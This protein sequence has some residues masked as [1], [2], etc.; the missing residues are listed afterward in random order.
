[1]LGD[2]PLPAGWRWVMVEDIRA[3]RQGAIVSGPFGSNIG[4]RFFVD[5]GIP[6]IRGNNLTLGQTEFVDE[7]F[8]YITP[9]KAH[10]LRNCE[11]VAGDLVFTAAGTLGQVGLIPN[12]S[13]YPRYIISNKQLRLRCDPQLALPKYLY[14]WFSAPRMRQHIV[15]QNTGASVPLITLGTLRKLPIALPPLPVQ[16]KI[17][18]VLS[19]YDDLIENNTRR[20]AILEEMAQAL[21]REWFVHFR[22]PGHARVPL[23]ESDLGMIPAGWEVVPLEAVCSRITDGSHWSPKTVEQG[24]PMASVK[25]MH[26]WGFNLGTCRKIAE[27][28]FARL[29][30]NDCKPLKGDVLVAKDGSYLKHIFAVNDDL[31]LVILSSI[32]LLRPDTSQILPNYLALLLLQPTMK[33][34]MLGYVSGVAIP[35]IVLKD[36][37]RFHIVV[38]PIRTQKAF[39]DLVE[40]IMMLCQ[41][42]TAKNV[43][44]SHTR[45][46]LMPKL[47]SGEVDVAEMDIAGAE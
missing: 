38:A 1:M 5:D 21:Y 17:A 39:N 43:A 41:T 3:T 32:A 30:H 46:L 18:A 34:R 29:V 37:R 11:A 33:A 40:P 31:E 2:S 24:L 36:F 13:R 19:A 6:V 35:R 25:D 27:D 15:N 4:K 26:S 16:R 9:E 14:Y 23:V 10:E 45:D 22:Y 28:D 8:V 42:L 12:H 7:G 44:L 20:I 47:I